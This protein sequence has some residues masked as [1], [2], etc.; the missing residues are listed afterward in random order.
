MGTGQQQRGAPMIA[1]WL[2]WTL[3]DVICFFI[4]HTRK[5]DRTITG[6]HYCKRCASHTGKRS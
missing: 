1:H 6:W 5:T 3:M 2:Y 4:G